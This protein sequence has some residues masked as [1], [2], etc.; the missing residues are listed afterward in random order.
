M[1]N[2]EAK[3]FKHGKAKTLYLTIPANMA[4]DSMFPFEN[5]EVVELEVINRNYIVVRKHDSTSERRNHT[6][7]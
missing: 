7:P 3:L 1:K 6:K 4:L 5:G 2:G